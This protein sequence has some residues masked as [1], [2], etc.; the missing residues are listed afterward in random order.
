MTETQPSKD[1]SGTMLSDT[2]MDGLLRDFFRL[3]VPAGAFS[4]PPVRSLALPPVTAVRLR[5]HPAR[6]L[7]VVVSLTV[8]PLCLLMMFNGGH[9]PRIGADFAE[10]QNSQAASEHLLPVSS[11]PD[12]NTATVPVDENGLLLQETEQI[13]LNPGR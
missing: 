10:K 2:A 9:R 13:Q 4:Q 11:A 8:L 6:Q 12:A 5:R 1:R 3:E 7:A